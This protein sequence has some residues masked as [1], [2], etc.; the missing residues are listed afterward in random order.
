MSAASVKSSTVLIHETGAGSNPS[1]ALHLIRVRPIPYTAAK[2][3][4]EKHHPYDV[5]EVVALPVVDG[6]EAYLGWMDQELETG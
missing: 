5:P 1:A 4:I 6:S 3:L 2:K